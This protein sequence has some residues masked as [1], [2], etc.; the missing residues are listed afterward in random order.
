MILVSDSFFSD[1]IVL[2]GS[3]RDRPSGVFV[4]CFRPHRSKRKDRT[5]DTPLP[6]ARVCPFSS[7]AV[8]REILNR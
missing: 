7:L 6:R 2:R 5:I 1:L 4:V 3:A 8:P